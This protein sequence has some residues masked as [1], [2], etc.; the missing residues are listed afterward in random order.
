MT[1]TPSPDRI[2]E[3]SQR[4][5]ARF[6]G[7]VYPVV[8]ALDRIGIS[9]GLAVNSINPASAASTPRG[10]ESNGI[11]VASGQEMATSS[12]V[13]QASPPPCP[14]AP[15]AR[16]RLATGPSGPSH[17]GSAHLGENRGV[18]GEGGTARCRHGLLRIGC[19]DCRYAGF[20]PV[21]ISA[22]GQAY[23]RSANCSAL[24]DGQRFVDRRGGQVSAVEQVLFSDDRVADRHP[25]PACRP[26][27]RP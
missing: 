26:P 24:R 11:E 25:C 5:Y 8:T 7:L 6:A 20:K 19:T 16:S 17:H 3:S 13:W 1:E 14:Q 9:L 12:S 18:E 2:G 21:Y 4:A 22:G 10:H 27:S 15:L 23:H